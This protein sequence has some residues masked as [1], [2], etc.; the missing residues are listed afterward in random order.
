[1][2]LHYFVPVIFLYSC[3]FKI[4]FNCSF[5]AGFDKFY[6]IAIILVIACDK[7]CFKFIKVDRVMDYLINMD[8]CVTGFCV[9][10]QFV[11]CISDDSVF[12]IDKQKK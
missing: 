4:I 8:K 7:Y 2:L 5:I 10:D 1:M 11:D 12:K 6:Y 9:D 3:W